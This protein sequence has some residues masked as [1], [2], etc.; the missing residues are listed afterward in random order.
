M[1][2]CLRRAGVDVAEHHI[3][4][5]DGLE[6][7]FGVGVGSAARLG[8]AQVR[9]LRRPTPNFDVLVVGYPGHVDM[10]AARR[11][12]AGRPIVFNPLLSLYDSMI[13]DR[14]RWSDS[15][16]PARVLRWID[17]EAIRLADVTVADTE[18]H[19]DY[20]ATL[21]NVSRTRIQVCYLGAEEQYFAPGW[22][23][24]EPFR[25]LFYGK[26]I[27]LHG[28]DTIVEAIR[29]TP[30]IEYRLLGSGQLDELL[31]NNL[32][33][34]ARW[35]RWMPHERVA[36]ELR[37]AGCSLGIFG[38]TDKAMRVI[39][40][41]AFEALACGAPLITA[42]TPASRE[43][44]VDGVDRAPRAARRPACARRSHRPAQR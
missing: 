26:L 14:G 2:S 18:A 31:E 43:L 9:L 6:H 1:I 37:A 38:T 3:P 24:V 21:A 11:A 5:W 12:A 17:R 44:L 35:I 7:K 39:P 4:V 27:P 20:L 10:R 13:H 28:L 42:D 25:C 34:N 16:V 19:A 23:P 15:S 8:R 29:L 32:P 33:Q 40:N 41:K 36:D 22:N 30:D